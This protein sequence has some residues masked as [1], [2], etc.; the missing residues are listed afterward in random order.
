VVLGEI[1]VDNTGMGWLGD[2]PDVIMEDDNISVSSPV[3]SSVVA[4]AQTPHTITITS[5]RNN[6]SSS[7]MDSSF[8][9]ATQTIASQ[10]SLPSTV[11]DGYVPRLSKVKTTS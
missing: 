5:G 3:R 9:N 4:S 10:S 11:H 1:V 7:I 6:I 2:Q 8:T